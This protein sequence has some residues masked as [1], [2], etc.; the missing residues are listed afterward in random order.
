MEIPVELI[1]QIE[2]GN[3]VL[4][5][6]WT[7]SETDGVGE[8]QVLNE[9]VL[10]QLLAD[11]VHYPGPIGP[12][13]EVAEYFEV[14]RGRQ[15][16]IQYVCDVI[17][18]YI[19]HPP[20]YYGAVID[21]PFNIIVS[22]SLDNLLKRMLQER[23]KRF[24]SIVRDE[25]ISFIDDDKLLLVKLY[26]DIDNKASI[27][28]TKEDYIAFLDQL[29]SISDLLKYYFSTKTLLF[30]G[31]NLN[32]PH[33]LQL[34]AYANQR[35]KGYQR[36]AFAVRSNPSQHEKRLWEKRNLTILDISPEDFLA[37][38]ASSIRI[39][40]LP[41]KDTIGAIVV[42][43]EVPS[44]IHKSPYK[45]LSSYEEQDVDI[46][47]GRNHDITRAIQKLLS[48][49]IMILYGK[50]GFGKTSLLCAGII[51]RLIKSNYLPVY[52]RCAADPL[53][54][55]KINTVD[56]IRQLDGAIAEEAIAQLQ[57]AVSL[58]L[59]DFIRELKKVERRSLVVFVDQ[60]EEFFISLG[61]A[62]R[63]QFEEELAECVDSPYIDVTFSL[64]LREDFLPEL[65]ELRRLHGIFENRYRLKALID[66]AARKAITKPAEKFGITF[67]DGLVSRIIRELS[68][69]G[70]VD[71]AQLQIVCDRL[72]NSMPER[73]TQITIAL[74]EE[75]GGA[76]QILADYVDSILDS[77]GPKR[78][79]VAQRLL[80]SMVTSW[81][82]RTALRYS[83][84]V[85]ETADI[86]GWSKK[87][88]R[89]LLGD[90]VQVRLVRRVADVE[91]ESYELTHEHLIN[92][93]REW[94]D[95]E[96]LKV[97]EAQDLLRQEYNNW[98]R[99]R[100]PM[101][102]SALEIVD[103]QRER[104]ILNNKLIAFI[105]AA[106]VRHDF[107]FDYW[108]DRNQGNEQAI[109][110]LVWL[111]REGESSAKRLAGIALAQLTDDQ[112]ILDEI[113]SVYE[114][115]ANPNAVK[116]IEE[117][118][119]QGICFAEGFLEKTR[120][121]VEHR[122]TKN[123]VFVEAGEFLMGASKEEIDAIA[124]ANQIPLSFFEGQYPQRKVYVNGF[125]MDKFLVTNA[126]FQEF[127]PTH[128]FPAGHE[129]HPATNVTWYE[130]QEFARWVG[131]E[132]PTEEEWEKAARGTD[133]RRFAWGEE[134]DPDRCNT[135]LSGYGG[136][137]PVDRFPSGVSPC[138]CYDMSGN[139]WEW[140]STWLNEEKKQKVL[141]GSSWSKYGILPWCWYRFNYEPDSGYINV[142]FR[143]I[144]RVLPSNERSNQPGSPIPVEHSE[145]E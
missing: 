41:P 55:I 140:T 57:S 73:E 7:D 128:I 54:S 84:A 21:L 97:K 145:E 127:K 45:F 53:L 82:T 44:Y 63:K 49:K 72:Y 96:M 59:P 106:A 102:K 4:F 76:R 3:C 10:A 60:F 38:L 13:H 47:F 93:I 24:V 124:E 99:H 30:L 48:S 125:Y 91:E 20:G 113:Y 88:T 95:L 144:R 119:S 138:G 105:L 23:G 33:F 142:G 118:H 17:E 129:S 67:G 126:E 111:L 80:R 31:Y 35:T 131:K 37:K 78:R 42:A 75:L 74:Y 110:L 121:V 62:T 137:T 18:E 43:E 98:Q 27:V 11:R 6:G 58:P 32:D 92:K 68:E 133:G 115:V 104:L 5:L 85:L 116:R 39:R 29:P 134:W 69:K 143:C 87:D 12:L 136:T 22:T 36:R 14:E 25:E 77:F 108:L 2:K 19:D 132:L 40:H 123:M 83:D 26:G 46:F 117:L 61:N 139:V 9:R 90:L 28:I 65:H 130:A 16:L 50:S 100:I 141:K 66:E 112:T 103:A 114:S 122:F 64:S 15:A 109:D 70:Q 81:F 1:E 120:Q 89:E 86:P 51:P 135:R 94:I 8:S 107:E 101:D 71:P 34:Y 56:R 52:A 79:L